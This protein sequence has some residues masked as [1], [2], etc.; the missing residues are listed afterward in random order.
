MRRWDGAR[1]WYPT[2]KLVAA[3]IFNVTRVDSRCQ[4]IQARAFT[5]AAP[6]LIHFT[7]SVK[8]GLCIVARPNPES[9]WSGLPRSPAFIPA[10]LPFQAGFCVPIALCS[11]VAEGMLFA[12]RRCKLT[13]AAHQRKRCSAWTPP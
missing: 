7:C 2:T 1:I 11:I 10:E 3:P 9:F 4:A 8:Q 12:P 6:D 13:W 5:H